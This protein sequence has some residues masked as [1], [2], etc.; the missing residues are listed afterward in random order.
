MAEEESSLLVDI[1]V[2]CITAR[3][4]NLSSKVFSLSAS[5]IT[6]VLCSGLY[7]PATICDSTI[8]SLYDTDNSLSMSLVQASEHL[9]LPVT[10]KLHNEALALSLGTYL[11]KTHPGPV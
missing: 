6:L 10:T 9:Y 4:L 3:A 11:W 2:E 7:N 1:S 5:C 8:S